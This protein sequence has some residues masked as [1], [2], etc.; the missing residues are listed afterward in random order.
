VQE[1][2]FLGFR[3]PETLLI[4]AVQALVQRYPAMRVHLYLPPLAGLEDGEDRFGPWRRRLEALAE[5]G[6]TFAPAVAPQIVIQP[7]AT[8]SHEV[9][10]AIRR[11]RQAEEVPRILVPAFSPVGDLLDA[12]LRA[13]AVEF[14]AAALDAVET[15]LPALL[16]EAW[17]KWPDLDALRPF[18]ELL[19][20]LGPAFLDLQGRLA[21]A[22]DA[23][24]LR[25]LEAYRQGCLEMARAE[26]WRPRIRSGRDWLAELEQDWVELRLPSPPPLARFPMRRLDR[27]G[28]EPKEVL[29]FCGMNDGVFPP[30]S[31]PAFFDEESV[32]F[33]R[34]Q[35]SQL[36]LRLAW[37]LARREAVFGFSQFPWR[38][39]PCCP[40]PCWTP[41][42]EPAGRRRT[43]YWPFRLPPVIPTPRKISRVRRGGGVRPWDPTPVPCKAKCSDRWFWKN[44]PSVHSAPNTSTIMPNAR[45]ASS[46]AGTWVSRRSPKKT[47]RSRPPNAGACCTSCSNSPFT[48]CARNFFTIVN[49]PT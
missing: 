43:L 2:F 18:A 27:P 26:R 28:L 23:D 30:A 19:E 49:F 5:S 4:D 21:E 41:C 20:F 8:P 34:K 16:R 47:W 24:S 42:P 6:E 12:E 33:L 48:T 17:Q 3:L 36:A 1:C 15:Q 22:G 13:T 46:P 38:P 7:H 44:S 14:S 37:G 40:P 45:G 35:D 9:R 39:G 32:D 11:L 29:I 10:S 31:A 25:V